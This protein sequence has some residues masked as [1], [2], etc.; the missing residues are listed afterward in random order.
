MEKQV[1]YKLKDLP[2]AAQ[3][4]VRI[5]Q[6]HQFFAW[7]A[8]G[9][10][11]SIMVLLLQDRGFNLFDIALATAAFS[12]AT[13]LL[14]LPLGGLADGIGRKPV[15]M[16][17]IFAEILSL[18]VLLLF[19]SF[20]AAIIAHILYGIG[21]ALMSGT[22]DAWFIETF[23]KLAPRFGTVPIL[24]KAQFAAATGLGVGAVSG[25][26]LVDFLGPTLM[27]YG[28][29]KFDVA[30][31]SNLL[32]LVFV[33]GYTVFFIQED[34]RALNKQAIMSGF[35]NVPLIVRDSFHY[36]SRHHVISILLLSIGLASA[37]LFALEIFWVPYAKPLIDSQYAV[38]FIGII[39]AVYFFSMAIG[40]TFAEPIVNFFKGHNA[41]A[42]AF[43]IILSGTLYIALAFTTDIYIF[44]AMLFIL[45]AVLGAQGAPEQSLF[46]DYVPNEKRSTLLSL[47]S[48]L[49]QLGG[50][51]GML[52]L[53]FV[54]EKYSISTAWQL[55]G[56]LT[57][58]AG[59]ILLILPK[60]MA[61]T[62]P[63]NIYNKAT[64][65]D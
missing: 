15:F 53:G 42:L 11:M 22:L 62:A 64:D 54:A 37:A 51:V 3:K 28:F 47:Q 5:F 4:H 18:V 29:G 17:S 41:K 33:A 38:S 65:E 9:I 56:T 24:A 1:K 52:G 16:M 30:L 40:A 43:I 21:R 20:S 46:H 50:L 13:L 14:E 32:V 49:R 58:I 55:G 26:L 63:E 48:V 19:Y 59:L 31:I 60:R 61:E 34:R 6:I 25:G 39:A 27:T 8:L 57:I 35:E 12:A 44:V 2:N 7:G 36:A 23:N 45:N 10:G